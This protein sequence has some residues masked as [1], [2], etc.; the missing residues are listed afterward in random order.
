MLIARESSARDSKLPASAKASKTCS[1][2]L[3]LLTKKRPFALI[4]NPLH[5]QTSMS[6]LFLI[7]TLDVVRVQNDLPG[8]VAVGTVHHVAWRTPNDQQQI[9]W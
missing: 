4:N 3:A 6:T 8:I 1:V 2:L 9:A 7:V 5:V